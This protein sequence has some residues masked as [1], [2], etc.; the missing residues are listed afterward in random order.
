MRRTAK[1]VVSALRVRAM[2]SD[3]SELL[4]PEGILSMLDPSP[5]IISLFVNCIANNFPFR[6]LYCK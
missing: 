2:A 6:E 5:E 4:D 1:F 3:Q